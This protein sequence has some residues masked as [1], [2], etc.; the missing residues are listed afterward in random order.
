MADRELEAVARIES[1]PALLAGADAAAAAAGLDETERFDVRLAVEELCMNVIKHGYGAGAPGEI[2]LRFDVRPD[3]LAVVVAD[4]APLFDPAQ[5][6]P[7]D[8]ASD[9]R[10]RRVGGLGVHMVRQVMD[11]V[12]HAP[13]PGGGNLVTIEKRKH[14]A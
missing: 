1:L 10:E 6:P 14:G 4:R 7:P 9:W 5:A 13:R 11:R 3:G 2:T 12:S 8:L